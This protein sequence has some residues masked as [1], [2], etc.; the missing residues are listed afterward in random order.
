MR[1]NRDTISMPEQEESLR[2]TAAG[3]R[4]D[5]WLYHGLQDCHDLHELRLEST[6]PPLVEDLCSGP[7]VV[8][9]QPQDFLD[10]PEQYTQRLAT[11]RSNRMEL[12]WQV[13]KPVSQTGLPASR[14]GQLARS[15]V[16]LGAACSLVLGV[17]ACHDLLA[18]P[19]ARYAPG[20]GYLMFAG[21]TLLVMGIVLLAAS[22]ASTKAAKPMIIVG[23]SLA[24]SGG[25]AMLWAGLAAGKGALAEGYDLVAL[26]ALV[27][28][29]MPGLAAA[30]GGG[31]LA[32]AHR[33]S[34]SKPVS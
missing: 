24:V 2:V 11:S 4:W 31:M 19:P 18:P 27:F 14:E 32:A 7:V 34:G 26:F 33:R 13:V 9:Q 8:V 29:L 28:L 16:R 10:T 3:S 22:F 15:V 23:G 1:F 30:A 21:P 20:L 6:A 12:R 5:R 25:L 17:L